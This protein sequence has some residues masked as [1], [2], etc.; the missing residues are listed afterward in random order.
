VQDRKKSR[1]QNW[2]ASASLCS[3]TK[4]KEA[5][6]HP[7]LSVGGVKFYGYNQFLLLQ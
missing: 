6:S 3:I 7:K 2:D 4:G 5:T 1:G